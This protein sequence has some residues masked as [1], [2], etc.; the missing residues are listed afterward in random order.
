MPGVSPKTS[1]A[2]LD[3]FQVRE[4]ILALRL[5]YWRQGFVVIGRVQMDPLSKAERYLR[6]AEECVTLAHSIR[7]FCDQLIA[8]VLAMAAGSKFLLPLNSSRIC[9]G[10]ML[11]LKLRRGDNEQ[12]GPRG[13]RQQQP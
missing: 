2:R 5:I 3:R 4:P 6:Q 11:S 10:S 1:A 13:V 12:A 8:S 9:A 7:P